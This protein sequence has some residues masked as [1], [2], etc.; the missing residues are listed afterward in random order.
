MEELSAMLS[1]AYG[2]LEGLEEHSLDRIRILI[3][4][5]EITAEI[6]RRTWQVSHPSTPKP[7][8]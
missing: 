2:D 6:N 1:I 4:I 3:G 7:G 5:R 8:R